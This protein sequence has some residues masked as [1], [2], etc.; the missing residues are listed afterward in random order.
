[1]T[2]TEKVLNEHKSRKGK[3][4]IVSTVPINT[5]DELSTFYTPGVAE[6]SRYISGDKR[7]VYDY[8][9]KGNMIAIV[10]DGTRVLGLGNVGPEAGL[11]VM[12]GK[13]ILFKKFGGVDAVPLCISV[14]DESEIIKFVTAI[15]PTFGAINIEDIESPKSFRIVDAL[16]KTLDIPVFHDDQQGTG[17]VVLAALLNSLRLAEKKKDAR[18][19]INGAGS[20]GVGI[21]RLLVH[22]GLRNLVVLDS[23]GIIYRGRK[24]NMNEFKEEIANTTNQEARS[25]ALEDAVTGADVLIG[26]S[27]AGAFGSG[28]IA[29]MNQ[30]PIVF[31]MANP[32]PEI[33]YVE[34]R[35]AG[36]FIA[37][38]GRSDTPNQV[39][40]LLAFPS[41]MRGLLDARA[42]RINYELLEGASKAI[43]KLAGKELSREKILPDVLDK[44][45]AI[46]VATSVSVAVSEAAVRTGVA[47]IQKDPKEI[48]KQVAERINRYW[49]VERKILR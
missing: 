28:L 11:P 4:E 6:V 36:A 48:R 7:G 29:T 38:T 42:R 26:V 34:A 16:S 3:Y 23:S 22:A 19:V 45:A 35:D 41:I 39:N 17:V 49:R 20:A 33:G 5:R 25:G 46:K 31:A 10:S 47:A 13:A 44:K 27:K 32:D 37:A 8:T 1:M 30:K 18:I 9:T 12:E 15:A 24:E 2:D 40:N 43:A 14:H 21:V